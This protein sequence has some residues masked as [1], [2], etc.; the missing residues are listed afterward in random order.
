MKHYFL[1]LFSALLGGAVVAVM[2]PEGNKEQA[3]T[4][5][6]GS[7][8]MQRAYYRPTNKNELPHTAHPPTVQP[9][10]L[11]EEPQMLAQVP[12]FQLPGGVPPEAP[13][14]RQDDDMLPEERVAVAV[15]EMVN[16]CVVNI[17]TRSMKQNTFFLHETPSEGSGSG[18][19]IDKSGHI[20]TNYHVIEGAREVQVTLSDGKTLEAQLVGADPVNDIAVIKIDTTADELFPVT[21]GDSGRLKV[22]MKVFALG[23]PFG[24]ERTLTTGIISSL[25]R[26]LRVRETRTIKS[27]IQIDAAIN[28]GS[29][30]GPLLDCRGH[31]V[32]MN[33]AIASNT[34]QSAG[35]GF[36]I[37]SNLIS[38]IVGELI[39][40][41]RVIRPEVGIR[42]VYPTSKGLLIASLMPGGPAELAG[43]RGPQISRRRRG[44]FLYETVDRSAADL[45]VAVDQKPVKTADEFLSY[46]E[47]K[48]PGD[49][50]TIGVIRESQPVSIKV[51]L[52]ESEP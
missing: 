40:H 21:F 18:S 37:P 26:T 31:L 20:L 3:I 42:H 49:E 5:Q 51:R 10:L 7:P 34:G 14:Q 29:S 33:T 9:Q 30:G 11:P 41:G 6:A 38:R 32:G 52:S 46:I 35:V 47:T 1:C 50:V 39:Q 2:Q 19:V 12:R 4:V 17:S 22:G 13:V 48:R 45:I 24:L 16:R 36:S 8:E 23:N 44:A 15:Y 28:P 43:L 25:N 27:I